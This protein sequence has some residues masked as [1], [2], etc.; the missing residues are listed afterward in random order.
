VEMD[1][2]LL[3]ETG[4]GLSLGELSD[5]DSTDSSND[6]YSGCDDNSGECECYSIVLY[7]NITMRYT[8]L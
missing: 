8:K 4:L 3:V 7:H 6:L 5:G 2:E 1:L